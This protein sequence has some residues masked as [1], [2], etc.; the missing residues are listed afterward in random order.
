MDDQIQAF[1][2]AGLTPWGTQYVAWTPTAEQ[3]KAYEKAARN[4]V[5][6]HMAEH[7]KV[8]NPDGKPGPAVL[9]QMNAAER[10]AAAVD[11]WEMKTI[12]GFRL[13]NVVR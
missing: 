9:I 1:I 4:S 12:P 13:Q 5:G 10:F 8:E 11:A 7:W 2:K 6:R 3:N